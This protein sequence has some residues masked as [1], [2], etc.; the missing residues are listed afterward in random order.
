MAVTR[1]GCFYFCRYLISL[2]R[3]DGAGR[4]QIPPSRFARR[5]DDKSFRLFASVAGAGLAV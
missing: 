4:K 3:I 2:R 5:R 1:V